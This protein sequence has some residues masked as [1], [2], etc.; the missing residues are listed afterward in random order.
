[1]LR[2]T[3][4]SALTLAAL[5][6]RPSGTGHAAICVDPLSKTQSDCRTVLEGLPDMP[7]VHELFI[8]LTEIAGIRIKLADKDLHFDT[9]EI[10]LA[11]S[12]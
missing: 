9:S 1:M 4:I 7:V 11:L 5:F 6:G 12:S 10:L 2:R 8:D 3:A